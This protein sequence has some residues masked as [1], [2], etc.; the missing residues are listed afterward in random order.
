[1]RLPLLVASMRFILHVSV[2]CMC[3]LCSCCLCL[4]VYGCM[5]VLRVLAYVFALIC[6][7]VPIHCVFCVCMLGLIVGD[8]LCVWFFMVQICFTY[9]T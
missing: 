4:F 8:W 6:C 3:V 1:M 9:H 5:L 2:D 7:H